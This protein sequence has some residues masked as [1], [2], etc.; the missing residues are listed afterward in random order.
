MTSK[1]FPNQNNPITTL[2]DSFSNSSNAVKEN[3]GFEFSSILSKQFEMN[4]LFLDGL[5]STNGAQDLNMLIMMLLAKLLG[6]NGSD[7]YTLSSEGVPSGNPVIGKITQ[8]SHDG[9]TALDYGIPVGTNIHST[10]DGKVVF[11]GWN[12][13]GYGN[14]VI[15]QNGDFKTYYAHLSEI[16]VKTGQNVKEGEV[17]GVS[18]NTGNSTGPHL[19]Y[20][21]RKNNQAIN[22]LLTI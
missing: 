9:H 17:I 22:P 4:P 16:P 3:G 1:I 6:E 19:H 11:A 12:H 2:Y 8:G 20:E 14:L 13:E 21:I 5:N 18:G 7:S 15:V 10:M